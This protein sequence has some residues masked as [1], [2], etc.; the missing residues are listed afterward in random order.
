[1][2]SGLRRLLN[3]GSRT[4]PPIAIGGAGRFMRGHAFNLGVSR[5]DRETMMRQYGMSGT[6]YAIASLLAESAA[7][8]CWKL[9][10]KAPVDG[11]V[12]YTTADKGTDQR[13]Q[14][15]QHA[16]IQ[17]WNSP[18]DLMSGFEFREGT[19]LHQELTGESAWVIDNEI[20]F[21]T[22]MWYVRP[23]RFEPC[24]GE[25]GEL[26][27][28]MYTG[29]DGTQV[30]LKLNEVIMEKR[31][32]PLDPHRG[33]GPV[34]A[35]MPN[36]QQQRYATE[37]QRNLFLNGANPG[38]VITVPNKLNDHEFDEMVDRWRESHRGVAR[39][40]HIGVLEAGATWAAATNSNKDMEYGQLRLAN[41][42]ELREAWRVHK[43]MLGTSDD[44]NRA[45]AQSA[46]EVFVAWQVIPRLNRRRDTL[47]TKLLPLF[48]QS[49][50]GVEFDYDDPSPE[51]AEAAAAELVQKANAA[52]TLIDAGF[53]PA[54]VCEVV[55]LPD[56]DCVPQGTPAQPAVQPE[57]AD[58]TQQAV[59][60]TA[61]ASVTLRNAGA[62]AKVYE[63]AAED[64][65][66]SALAWMHHAMWKG[67]VTV[68][69][70]HI[71][72]TPD[73]M[74][75]SDPDH[76]QHFVKKMQDGKKLKP[77]ILVKTPSGDKLQL[78][79]GHHRYLASAQ[80]STPIRAYV[81]TVDEEHGAWETMH[82]SQRAKARN[83][84]TNAAT[85]SK[86]QVNYRDA[87]DPKREC[88]TCSMFV[89]PHGCTLVKGVIQAD[90]V[91]DRWDPKSGTT[92]LLSTD[93]TE[94]LRRVL[95][96]GYVPIQTGGR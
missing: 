27:G 91:C 82:S 94:L 48:G 21:P 67:P 43:T 92:A 14:V 50:V 90:D 76:V 84:L 58:Q 66:P 19:Q 28:W 32:D 30:P 2:K 22:S 77:V 6:V 88:G 59:T 4:Q 25:H 16:A 87:T 79:D 75:P 47:N 70:D 86:A 55:G 34:Q 24:I 44:V 36:I 35:I 71:D 20:G 81:G 62:A 1:M 63:I 49:G 3:Q 57:T 65:P 33:L 7:T 69:L 37:Y 61:R 53:D 60:P 26:T 13:T 12:R 23:D 31:P 80:L 40:G 46:E 9:Y 18:N 15:V 52:K 68:P 5:Q 74:D 93:A 41:R 54:D 72:W 73:A 45:N 42:D 29:P 96:N 8:P 78:V 64:Y 56:M 10:R 85:L 17:L 38:G 83:Q 39:A 95:S 11:R 89:A 51:N